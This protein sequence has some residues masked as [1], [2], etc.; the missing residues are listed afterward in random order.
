MFDIS[1]ILFSP[2]CNS[3]MWDA[4]SKALGSMPVSWLRF[5]SSFT[6]CGRRPKRPSELMR[7]SSLSL[8]K[9]PNEV[10]YI[11]RVRDAGSRM[12]GHGIRKWT[13]SSVVCRGMSRGISFRPRPVQSTVVPSQWHMA[14]QSESMRHSPDSFIRNSSQEPEMRK[15]GIASVGWLSTRTLA[16]VLH[17]NFSSRSDSIRRRCIRFGDSQRAPLVSMGF[18]CK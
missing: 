2:S 11:L 13:Y 15:R 4:P 5:N 9:L 17:L 12:Q 7:P 8:S 3:W 6:K 18:L 16:A 10:M 1:L 14:G